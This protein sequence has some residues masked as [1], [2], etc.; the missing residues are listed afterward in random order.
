M[1]FGGDNF[2][3]LGSLLVCPSV[4][5]EAGAASQKQPKQTKTKNEPTIIL[6]KRKQKTTTTTTQV[7]VLRI[8]MDS[9]WVCRSACARP[10]WRCWSALRRS[11]WAGPVASRKRLPAAPSCSVFA[12]KE[13]DALPKRFVRSCG[14]LLLYFFFQR[15]S[16]S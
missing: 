12:S 4:M 1:L 6:S 3:H 13:S 2:N 10:L 11:T 16:H 5:F 14:F 9:S 15:V 8:G 7:R